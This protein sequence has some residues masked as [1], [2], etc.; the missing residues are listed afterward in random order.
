MLMS[1]KMMLDFN[2]F[3]DDAEIL[4]ILEMMLDFDDFEDDAGF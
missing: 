1:L 4:P 2:E 3:E